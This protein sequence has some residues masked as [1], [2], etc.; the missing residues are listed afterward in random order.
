MTM[1]MG[2]RTKKTVVVGSRFRMDTECCLRIFVLAGLEG[3]LTRYRSF[4]G[5]EV[6]VADDG[7]T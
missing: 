6:A 5:A 3:R 2:T 7:Q 4:F 1:P